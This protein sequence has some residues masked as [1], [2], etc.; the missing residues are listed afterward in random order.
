MTAPLS[1]SALALLLSAV[2]LALYMATTH[3]PLV[4]FRTH[5][6]THVP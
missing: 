2:V 1:A 4:H 5:A 6:L 3:A